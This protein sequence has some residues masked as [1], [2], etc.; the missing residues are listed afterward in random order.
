MSE[1]FRWLRREV[2]K[3]PQKRYGYLYEKKRESFI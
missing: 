3:N 2:E 1:K